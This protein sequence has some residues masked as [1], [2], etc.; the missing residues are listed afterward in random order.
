MSAF[1]V[2]LRGV[3]KR[4]G[5]FTAVDGIDLSVERGQFATLLGPSGCGKTTTLRM[6]G[7]LEHPDAGTIQVGGVPVGTLTQA[8]RMTRMVFQNYALFPHMTVEQ[9]V[10]FGLRMQKLARTDIADRIQR[11]ASLLGLEAQLKKYPSQMSGGQQQRV[12]LARALVTRP[13]VLLLDEPLGALDLKMRK[14][15]QSELKSLQREVGITF[16][17]VTHDQEEALNLSDTIVVMDR[18]RIVQ[19]GSPREIYEQPATAY[20]A[21]FI[22]EANLIP[23]RLS[24]VSEVHGV[25]DC[26][27][28]MVRGI[29]APD[30]PATPGGEVLIAIR[31]E[32]IIVEP[33][34][35]GSH[36]HLSGTIT[37]T[38]FLGSVTRISIRFGERI[39]RADVAAAP[40]SKPGDMVSVRWK[41][42]SARLLARDPRFTGESQTGNARE[43]R[44][45]I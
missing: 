31:P 14:H 25:A 34:S 17:Y 38:A 43:G 11:I 20:V 35:S 28:G 45:S 12:A 41:P 36:G 27:L 2:E 42:E 29:I 22:G 3:V 10:A 21:D 40:G 15:M 44:S 4:F 13:R 19:Q 39:L 5:S 6:V 9:N 33:V 24:S 30:V 26:E 7:G 23:G 32:N 37:E 1:D 18:G 8:D 16:I